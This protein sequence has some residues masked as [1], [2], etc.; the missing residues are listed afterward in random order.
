MWLMSMK[1]VAALSSLCAMGCRCSI[2]VMVADVV[3]VV[4]SL[5]SDCSRTFIVIVTG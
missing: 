1:C 3:V 5:R 2:M 4:V